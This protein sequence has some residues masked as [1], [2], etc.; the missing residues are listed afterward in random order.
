M[1][2]TCMHHD[3]QNVIQGNIFKLLN[4]DLLSVTFDAWR[5]CYV[6]KNVGDKWVIKH[7]FTIAGPHLLL[8]IRSSAVTS[9]G[10]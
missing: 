1:P 3:L 8:L 5:D 10:Y 6:L 4:D 7:A 2:T 9:A